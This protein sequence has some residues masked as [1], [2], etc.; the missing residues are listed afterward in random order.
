MHSECAESN[1]TLLQTSQ[2]KCLTTTH[3][4]KL[5]RLVSADRF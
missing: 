2:A 4:K 1:G 5:T 3:K